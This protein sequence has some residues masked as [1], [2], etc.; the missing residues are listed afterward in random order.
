[1]RVIGVG[2]VKGYK[3][4]EHSGN[5]KKYLP[6]G[7]GAHHR[8]NYEVE[9]QEMKNMKNPEHPLHVAPEREV[10]INPGKAGQ[11]HDKE[12]STE[13]KPDIMLFRPIL[14]VFNYECD[15]E[16]KQNFHQDI[17]RDLL[18]SNKGE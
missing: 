17:K 13:S 7:L 10:K 11:D 1:V 5:Y 2:R 12:K 6:V 4:R 16:N 18:G 14:R 15:P 9:D 8:D 3:N